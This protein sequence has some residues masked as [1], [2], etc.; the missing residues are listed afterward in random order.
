MTLEE[1]SKCYEAAAI[2]L[3]KRLRELRQELALTDDPEKVWH[4]KRRIAEL[5][6]M[7][8]QTNDLAWL[9]KNYYKIGGADHD[10]RYGFNGKRKRKCCNT[11]TDEGIDS[12]TRR[13]INRFAKADLQSVLL[14]E[15]EHTPNRSE[16]RGEQKHNQPDTEAC[17]KESKT[18]CEVLP[19]L[20]QFFSDIPQKQN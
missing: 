15:E 14:R 1:L 8:T 17:G 12:D 11:R 18:L 6:P 9:L 20:S 10:S 4:L 7:L 2:P 13:R 5:V 16:T 3:R 19:D